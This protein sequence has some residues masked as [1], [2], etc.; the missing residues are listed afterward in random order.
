MSK[1]LWV[2]ILVFHA[3]NEYDEIIGVYS[4]R[5]QAI[6]DMISLKRDDDSHSHSV[7]RREVIS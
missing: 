7:E 1:Q 2:Y 5:K 6:K 3:H 4:T